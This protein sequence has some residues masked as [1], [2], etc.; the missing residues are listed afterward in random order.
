MKIQ[1]LSFEKRYSSRNIIAEV[2]LLWLGNGWQKKLKAYRH[3][4][5][6]VGQKLLERVNSGFKWTTGVELMLLVIIV[7]SYPS[8]GLQ[9][10]PLG[11]VYSEPRLIAPKDFAYETPNHCK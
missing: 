2:G 5:R 10:K 1:L 4:K 11:F 6:D 9:K 8:I 3:R 7:A